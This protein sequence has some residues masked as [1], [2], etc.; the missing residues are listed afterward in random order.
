M[1]L[2][3][4]PV[5]VDVPIKIFHERASII[6]EPGRNLKILE[7]ELEKQRRYLFYHGK[8]CY[9]IGRHEDALNSLKR[10]LEVS[11]WT[12]EKCE[13]LVMMAKCKVSLGFT[14]DAKDLC[15]QTIKIEPNFAPAHNY[16]GQIAMVQGDYHS[17]VMWLENALKV[18]DI[19]YVFDERMDTKFNCY[20]NLIIAYH[21]VGDVS[22]ARMAVIKAQQISP[23]SEW[24]KDQVRICDGEND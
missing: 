3:E 22:A 24:I 2:G 8:E 17:A 14:E 15:L 5:V 12:A 19:N 4:K 9:E 1:F 16:L 20:G 18:K 23:D 10:Y 11:K 7:R 21:K 6:I 13:A